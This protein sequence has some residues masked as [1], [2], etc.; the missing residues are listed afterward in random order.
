MSVYFDQRDQLWR[1]QV[2]KNGRRLSTTARTREEADQ[3]E[4]GYRRDLFLSRI[5]ERPRRTIED[6]LLN[7]LDHE[8]KGL[9]SRKQT[10][11][12]ARALVGFVEGKPLE[13]LAQAWQD[14]RAAHPQ[15]TNSTLNRRGAILRRVGNLAFKWGWIDAPI[16]AKI[17]LLKE[18]PARQ[19]YLTRAQFTR[20]V[21]ACDYAPARDAMTIA[22]YAGLRLGEIMRLTPSSIRD[23]LIHVAISKNG[24]PR[25][26]PV[27]QAARAA[28]RRLPIPCKWRW[29]L[30]H[31]ERARAA[32]GLPHIRFHDLRHT[33]ASWLIQADA[34]PVTVRDLL[35]HSS[36]AVT[37]R[38]SHLSTAHLRKAVRRL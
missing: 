31:F 28:L 37:G 17:E 16:G 38:Y 1:V 11:S 19:I 33:N 35:G 4:A 24:K 23:D 36:L 10:E 14:Y 30:R 9:G 5:G 7:W 2:Q 6:A 8:A 22:A 3:L 18:N 32:A 25:V 29:I 27:H 15:L 34:D 26:V 12:H 21:K 13:D 20:L